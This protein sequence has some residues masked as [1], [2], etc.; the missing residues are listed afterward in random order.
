[1]N[2]TIQLLYEAGQVAGLLTL[3]V[4][5]WLPKSALLQLAHAINY[6]RR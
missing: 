6:F 5:C 1:M 4:A 2:T 3:I